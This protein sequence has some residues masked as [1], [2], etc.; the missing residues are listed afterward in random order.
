MISAHGKST[1][2][3]DLSKYINITNDGIVDNENVRYQ[4]DLSEKNFTW[5]EA[6]P[7]VWGGDVN[8]ESE[9]PVQQ[10]GTKAFQPKMDAEGPQQV[11]NHPQSPSKQGKG[12][13]KGH[14]PGQTGWQHLK[15]PG[16]EGA[17]FLSAAAVL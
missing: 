7:L 8:D 6:V 16:P 9:Q 17:L 1:P 5:E 10:A 12:Q 14:L 11:I 15:H 4:V 2:T 13:A 3:F